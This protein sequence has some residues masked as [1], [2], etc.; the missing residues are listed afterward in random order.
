M[1]SQIFQHCEILSPDFSNQ[2]ILNKIITH[3]EKKEKKLEIPIVL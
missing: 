3:I 2:S 1:N